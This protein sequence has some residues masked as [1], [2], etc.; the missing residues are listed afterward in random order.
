MFRFKRKNKSANI[1]QDHPKMTDLELVGSKIGLGCGLGSGVSRDVLIKALNSG[2]KYFDTSSFYRVGALS[3]FE[4]ILRDLGIAR[5]DVHLSQK[6]WVTDLGINRSGDGNAHIM[7]LRSIY[8]E[9]LSEFNLNAF[10][11]LVIHWPLRMDEAGF[12]DE[13]RMEEIWP[14]LEELVFAGYINSIGV[15]NFNIIEMQRLFSFAR[16]KPYSAQIEFNPFAHNRELTQYC[17]SQGVKVIGHTPFHFGQVGGNRAL[18]EDPC[19]ASL[20][21]KYNK[22]PSQIILSWI[23]RSGVFPIP[24]TSNVDHVDD[25]IMAA[26]DA[27]LDQEDINSIFRLNRNQFSYLGNLGA[28]DLDHH[29][30]YHYGSTDITALVPPHEGSADLRSISIYDAHFVRDLKEALT[31]GAG[32]VILSGALASEVRTLKAN[33]H[34]FNLQTIGRYDVGI[35]NAG[36]EILHIIDDP[37]VALVVESLLGWDCIL[38]NIALSTSRPAP[39]NVILGPHQDSP[40]DRKPGA[41]LP[42]PSYP[43]VLQCIVAIDE[44]TV[45][46]GPLYIIPHSHKRRQRV[47]L[48]WQGGLTPGNIPDEAIKV[49]CP[50]GSVVIAVGHIWHG[51]FP[52]MTDTPRKG[53]LMEF[54]TSFCDPAHKFT[55]DSLSNQFIQNCSRRVVRILNNGPGILP[56]FQSA[57]EGKLAGFAKRVT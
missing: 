43:I 36:T 56:A 2:I 29:K 44:F 5:E 45:D 13:F 48:P 50:E 55:A 12:P 40:F 9:L 25:F 54:V 35:F 52:N 57:R 27:Y 37:L 41:P 38:D 51:S 47:T 16:I 34:R 49:I 8:E 21:Q 32:F 19:I 39:D 3:E 30:K 26:D 6:L 22:P 7:S 42:P 4:S 14:Q 53:L 1:V 11:S 23:M 15:S 24:A 31:E 18:F 28:F 17:H 10:D 33:M 46:N 20:S